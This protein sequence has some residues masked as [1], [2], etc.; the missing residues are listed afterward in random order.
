MTKMPAMQ[1]GMGA[2]GI[3]FVVVVVVFVATMLLKLGPAYLSFM[4]VKSVMNEVAASPEPVLGGLATLQRTLD[5]RM[6]VNDVRGFDAKSFKIKKRAGE[7]VFDLTVDYEQ[8]VHLF[9]NIDAVLTFHH[10]VVVKG[11]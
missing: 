3:L 7:E 4:T 10:A 2:S 11:R 9:F 6:N 1:K 8:R 5:S